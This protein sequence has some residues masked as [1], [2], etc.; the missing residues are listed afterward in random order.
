MLESTSAATSGDVP[1]NV[2]PSS[3]NVMVA[4]TGRSQFS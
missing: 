4:N 2:R 1:K 3:P